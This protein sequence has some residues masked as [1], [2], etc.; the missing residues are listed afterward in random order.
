[1]FKGFSWS[2]LSKGKKAGI[3]IGIIAV[4]LA[5]CYIGVAVYFQSHFL[6]N[7]TVN[8]FDASAKTVTQVRDHLTQAADTYHLTLDDQNG[9]TVAEIEPD[10]IDLT[11]DFSEEEITKLVSAQNEWLWP[12]ALFQE[13]AFETENLLNYDQEKFTAIL[14]N[15]P[16]VTDTDNITETTD[17]TVTYNAEEGQYEVVEEV[18]GNNIDMEQFTEAAKNAVNNLDDK[19]TVSDYYVQ[20]TVTK[21]DETLNT[22]ADN[23]NKVVGANYTITAGGQSFT[24][25]KDTI[26]TW[27]SVDENLDVV[28]NDD[29]IGSYVSEIASSVNTYGK[30]HSFKTSYGSTIT[31]SGG[32]Y[33]WKVDQAAEIAQIKSDLAAGE[34]VS[35]EINYSSTAAA[36][37]S[38]DIGSSYV[39]INLT[40]Q[41]VFVY[42][43]GAKVVDTP[44]VTGNVAEGNGTP[45]GVYRIAN[46]ET[47]AVLKGPTWESP[48]SYW[49][50]FNG[51]IGLHDASWRSVF[52]GAI[53]Q[54]NGSHGCVNLPSGVAGSVY[55]NVY[56]GMPVVVY[57]LAGTESATSSEAAN[58]VIKKISA[59]GTVTLDSEA[60]ITDARASY[61]ALSNS[62][63]ASVSN[64]STLS[65][66]EAALAE[67][68]GTTVTTPDTSV[69]SE[70]SNES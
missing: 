46:K 12:M 65:A 14:N 55:S 20:P 25:P 48:V 26:A 62:E 53:Y 38:A 45:A 36:S 31:V 41:R 58:A 3:I 64:Y 7:S 57:T 15:L 27:I 52:G 43:N 2:G 51:G 1:M 59:I 13:N 23:L 29:L 33:G 47:N 32:N 35:R 10:D 37:G 70:A 67:L 24:I 30:S 11:V 22:T 44:C 8:G 6:F 16:V 28:Y 54:T 5:A 63:K 34:D 4:I 18:Y 60:A 68:K 17:A 66:A 19:V 9:N 39:E 40:A 50:P 69:D 42:V 49:M 61:N 21:D 56:A